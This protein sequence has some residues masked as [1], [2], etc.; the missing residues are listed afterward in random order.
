[1]QTDLSIETYLF[2]YNRIN[3]LRLN[4]RLCPG[5]NNRQAFRNVGQPFRKQGIMKH[6]Q[7]WQGTSIMKYR[8]P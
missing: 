4:G 2:I 6:G 8:C 3:G 7:W 5:S 1:M